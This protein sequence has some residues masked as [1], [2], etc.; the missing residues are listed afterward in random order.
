MFLKENFSTYQ[1]LKSLLATFSNRSIFFF[2]NENTKCLMMEKF[3]YKKNKSRKDSN[4]SN[5][6]S[7]GILYL[8]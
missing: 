7:R 6:N 3:P 1:K 8:I 5:S 2:E 4:N